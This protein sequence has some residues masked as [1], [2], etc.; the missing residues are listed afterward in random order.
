MSSLVEVGTVDG[1]TEGKTAVVQAGGREL[2]LVRWGED[3]YALRNICPHMST[4]LSNNGLVVSH[5]T[6]EVGEIRVDREN[7]I[8]SCPWHQYEY[9]LRDGHCVTDAGLRVRSYNVL[10]EEGRIFV[11]LSSHRQAK[12]PDS[13]ATD[14][15]ENEQR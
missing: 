12:T 3:V 9:R 14:S 7:P 10:L 4:A 2:V 8:I 1:L 6:G 15:A 11:D 5:R 13:R